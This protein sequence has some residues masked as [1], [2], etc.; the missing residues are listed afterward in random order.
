M[1]KPRSKKIVVDANVAQSAGNTNDA[2]TSQHSRKALFA[3]RESKLMLVLSPPFEDEWKRHE[4][5]F[6]RKWRVS[7]Q[8]R[9]LIY[10]VPEEEF[11][12]LRRRIK[13]ISDRTF[14]KAALLKDI[15][16]FAC[17]L[18]TNRVI[19][20]NEVRLKKHLIRL[21]SFEAKVLDILWASPSTE[22]DACS[23]WLQRGAKHE[24]SR[25]LSHATI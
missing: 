2:P 4:S 19:V 25:L 14:P 20:S 23:V 1:P 3:I 24:K 13:E 12:V 8:Q 22:G 15:H 10:W 17:A 6:S 16:V 7:M 18:A 9:G 11:V 21:G 5:R